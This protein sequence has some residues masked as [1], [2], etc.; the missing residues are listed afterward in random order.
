MS[1]N[2]INKELL[3]EIELEM[4]SNNDTNSDIM[5]IDNDIKKKEI[6]SENGKS[7]FT[8]IKFIKKY[9]ETNNNINDEHSNKINNEDEFGD[10][11]S[12]IKNNIKTRNTME[13][14]KN[15]KIRLLSASSILSTEEKKKKCY[16]NL[17]LIST[18]REKNPRVLPNSKNKKL[19]PNLSM[20]KYNINK[21]NKNNNTLK[22][23]KKVNKNRKNV[24]LF[25]N[26]NKDREKNFGNLTTRKD[27]KKKTN[28]NEVL[29][30]F[31]EENK[32][33]KKRLENKRKEL[34]D[35][36]NINNTGKPN[37]LKKNKGGE[38]KLPKK[39]LTRQKELNDKLNQKKKKLIEENEKKK[40]KE[41]K[42]IISESIITKKN[43][44][45]KRNKSDD[46]FI[47]RLY[48]QDV[49]KR[50]MERDYMQNIFLPTFKPNV[51]KK[52]LNKSM[53]KINQ[54]ETVLNKYNE[55]QNPQLLI[56]YFT[57]NNN[58]KNEDSEN[59]FRQ[60]IFHKFVKKS[61]KRSN[62]VDINE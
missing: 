3:T 51:P 25:I 12:I 61:K 24:E 37:I 34:K 15:K 1:S 53:D 31:E 43:K 49:K 32:A 2:N 33:A 47:D 26:K 56:D 60:K 46:Q 18:T 50:K 27:E 52:K 5:S 36:E 48:K 59:L 19:K 16:N 6:I 23:I 20:P 39:F 21:M 13:N 44:K 62:S 45:F 28:F 11:T 54:I 14:N 40:E 42:K 29:K 41:Y 35:K 10:L 22:D 9:I 55:K 38:D 57:K 58:K 8:E 7:E 4:K 17:K 30:R